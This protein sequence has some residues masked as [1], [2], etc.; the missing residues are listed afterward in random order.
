MLQQHSHSSFSSGHPDTHTHAPL[1]RQQPTAHVRGGS[2]SSPPMELQEQFLQS[3]QQ[4]MPGRTMS[5]R[6]YWGGQSDAHMDHMDTIVEQPEIETLSIQQSP[7][8][9]EYMRKMRYRPL[10]VGTTTQPVQ[11][12]QSAVQQSRSEPSSAFDVSFT[13]LNRMQ[14]SA[15]VEQPVLQPDEQGLNQLQAEIQA[16]F[17]VVEGLRSIPEGYVLN[18]HWEQIQPAIQPM[19]LSQ[20]ASQRPNSIRE[21][22]QTNTEYARNIMDIAARHDQRTSDGI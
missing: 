16:G 14:R 1:F 19:N 6:Y 22:A 21:R 4:R 8:V 2:S 11:Q 5:D 17:G 3:Q 18:E 12:R 13:E 20:P 9:E 10:M 7:E 15:F